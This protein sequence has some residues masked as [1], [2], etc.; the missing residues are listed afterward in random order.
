MIFKVFYQESIKE[1]PV[2][3]KTQTI[4]ME[5]ESERDVRLKLADRPYNIEFIAELKG[6]FLEFE[7]QREDFNVLEIR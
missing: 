6:D 5:A 2:R 3:E 7:K 1:V 4:Y